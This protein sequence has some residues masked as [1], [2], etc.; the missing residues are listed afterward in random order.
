MR[1]QLAAVCL[2]IGLAAAAPKPRD[3][4]GSHWGTRDNYQEQAWHGKPGRGEGKPDHS[5]HGGKKSLNVQVGPRPYYLVDNMDEGPLKEKLES[6]SEDPLKTSSFSI[7]HRGAPLMFPEHSKEGYKAA[8]RMGAGIVECDVSFTSD[9]ELVCRHSNCDLHY[10]TDILAHPE[11]AE[12]CSE[13]F[14]PYDPETGTEASAKCCT[15]DITLSEFKSLCAEMEATTFNA[16]NTSQYMGRIGSTPDWRTN[17]YAYSC[18]E[19]LSL[20]EQIAL[21]DSYGLNFTAEAKTPEIPMPFGETNYTQEDF[22]QQIVDTYNEAGIDADRVWLQ[23]FLPD[24]IFYWIANAPAYGLQA[25]YL[26]E[27]AD[28]TTDGYDVAVASLPE[29]AEK[30]VK[31]IAPSIWQLITAN[32]ETGEIVPS[33]Y[34]IA[35]KDAGLE[36]ITWSF[37]R[38]G[39][40][41]VDEGGYYYSSVANLI[42]NDGDEFTVIDVIA[43]KVGATKIF[44]DWAGT[45]TYYANCFGLV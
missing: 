14:V 17:M 32:N 11:L 37:E 35:A 13:P 16:V 22:A 21:V 43:Q 30:G 45:V 44:A 25:V 2:S 40:L 1:A 19:P 33:S 39:P 36:I 4:W 28:L 9:L 34:A 38:S 8:I 20:K 7:S 41:E 5:G 23:S 18:A 42:N 3:Q 27:R 31:I 10:T 29:L 26:D 15:S 24:D 6:C 12:K